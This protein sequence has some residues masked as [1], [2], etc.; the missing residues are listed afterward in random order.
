MAHLCFA[1]QTT[2]ANRGEHCPTC[3]RNLTETRRAW[4][5]GQAAWHAFLE[6]T[7]WYP[8]RRDEWAELRWLNPPAEPAQRPRPPRRMAVRYLGGHPAL[9]RLG[10]V[11]LVR[12]ADQV[13]MLS[14]GW[15]PTRPARV[16]I[17]LPAIR[18]VSS[19]RTTETSLD[20]SVMTAA[21][22]GARTGP[23]GVAIGAAIGRR[24]RIL[25]TVHVELDID[26]EVA[27]LVFRPLDEQ[28]TGALASLVRI[29]QPHQCRGR[30]DPTPTGR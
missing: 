16:P 18:S 9:S 12:E 19:Q 10:R 15:W 25:R 3:G 5:R 23:L 8:G 4:A 17:P 29:F 2:V 14:P 27:E 20:D 24:R 13:A 30:C 11:V 28:G 7:G 6:Q 1:C 26:G 21:I 22:G